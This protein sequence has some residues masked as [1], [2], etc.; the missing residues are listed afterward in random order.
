[1]AKL[2]RL[3]RALKGLR[4]IRR[5]EKQVAKF[6]LG[7]W[8]SLPADKS[9]RKKVPNLS[10]ATAACAV[11]SLLLRG[12]LPGMKY[13]IDD[14]GEIWPEY[15]GADQFKAVADYFDIPLGVAEALFYPRYYPEMNSELK[16][17]YGVARVIERLSIVLSFYEARSDE[18]RREIEDAINRTRNGALYLGLIY[19]TP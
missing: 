17:A 7:I 3:K 18:K 9:D 19:L 6:D 1:M 12:D 15:R 2:A 4:A 14:R 10:C 8:A 13:K 16:G 5:S 11:G